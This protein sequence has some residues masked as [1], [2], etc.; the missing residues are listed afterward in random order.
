MIQPADVTDA[1]L[2]LVSDHAK[3]VTGVTLP[4]DAGFYAK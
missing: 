1:V 4:V 3:Y 2:W